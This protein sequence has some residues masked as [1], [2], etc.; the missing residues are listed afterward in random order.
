MAFANF[1]EA[2]T[3]SKRELV[4]LR[5]RFP[6]TSRMT[7]WRIRNEPGFPAAIPLK[8]TEYFYADELDA[9]EEARRAEKNES[10]KK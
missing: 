2:N 3:M 5:D 10:T 6:T 4:R 7:R 8:G 1:S 9:Y